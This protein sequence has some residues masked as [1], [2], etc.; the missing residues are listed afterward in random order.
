M[1]ILVSLF[2]II[3]FQIAHGFEEY[4]HNNIN[5]HFGLIY[6]T[7]NG[8]SVETF[9]LSADGFQERLSRDF[10]LKLEKAKKSLTSRELNLIP[11]LELG[12]KLHNALSD[13]KQPQVKLPYIWKVTSSWS[14]EW[15]RKYAQWVRENVDKD[16]FVKY[17]IKTDCADVAVAI[18]WIFARIN[19]LPAGNRLAGSGR[20]FSTKDMRSSWLKYKTHQNWSQDKRFLKAL[21]YILDNTYTHSV[22][23]DS[24]PVALNKEYFREGTFFIY[25]SGRSGHTYF[26]NEI[27][28][29]DI[30]KVPIYTVYSTTPRR[31]R[32]LSYGLYSDS[33]KPKVDKQAYLAHRWVEL[34]NSNFRY[35]SLSRQPGYSLEQFN[36]EENFPVA[37]YKMITPGFSVE[38]ITNVYIES[39]QSSLKEREQVVEQGYEYC[40]KNDCSPGTAGYE[41]WS[42]PSRDKRMRTGYKTIEDL[43]RSLR[44][45]IK[46]LHDETVVVLGKKIRIKTLAFLMYSGMLSHEPWDKPERRWAFPYENFFDAFKQDLDSLLKAREDLV[47]NKSKCSEQTPCEFLSADW[48]N[49]SPLEIDAKIR[50]LIQKITGFCA[51]QKCPNWLESLKAHSVSLLGDEYDLLTFFQKSMQ[52]SF[53]PNSSKTFTAHKTIPFY[54]TNYNCA[55]DTQTC[56][57]KY[58]DKYAVYD[59]SQSKYITPWRDYSYKAYKKLYYHLDKGVMSVFD[60]VLLKNYSMDLGEVKYADLEGYTEDYF[61]IFVKDVDSNNFFYIFDNKTSKPTLVDKIPGYVYLGGNKNSAAIR[62]DQ[63]TK[64]TQ[65]NIFANSVDKI[66]FG[67]FY[68]F[69]T[70]FFDTHLSYYTVDS[71]SQ[72]VL[73]IHNLKDSQF[74]HVDFE[75]GKRAYYQFNGFLNNSHFLTQIGVYKTADGVCESVEGS[76]ESISGYKIDSKRQSSVFYNDKAFYTFKDDQVKKY[77]LPQS[78]DIFPHVVLGEK[79]RHYITSYANI[80]F[81]DIN[82]GFGQKQNVGEHFEMINNVSHNFFKRTKDYIDYSEL[83][84]RIFAEHGN[85]EMSFLAYPKKSLVYISDILNGGEYSSGIL[86]PHY[87]PEAD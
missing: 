48:K 60:P 21:D 58:L 66:E 16:F 54:I 4:Y 50:T 56:D 39:L 53:N 2:I 41:A 30:L 85:D 31:V 82:T 3:S 27:N 67:P 33:K 12:E 8:Y 49:E 1:K 35:I 6:A 63:S 15:E 61:Y 62:N 38:A 51:L 68:T 40:S 19:S 36:I 79:N 25:H 69:Q 29:G 20:F 73:N 24:Y 80:W 70:S 77:E 76:P 47:L 46:K 37:L 86:G 34:K 65:V 26:F 43:I 42:T 72:N 13:I 81:F 84:V 78:F 45:D 71:D 32:T 75:Q 64:F 28:H 83:K 55:K 7:Q 17:N 52:L 44:F 57:V 18:R 14:N 74:C 23:R 11:R 22:F 5:N 59:L 87:Y 9:K 10:F